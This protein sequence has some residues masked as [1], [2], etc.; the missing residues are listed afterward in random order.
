MKSEKLMDCIGQIDD[1]I[2]AEAD[3][4]LS[5]NN[6]TIKTRKDTKRMTLTFKWLVPVAA[7]LAITIASVFTVPN[8]IK[9][10]DVTPPPNGIVIIGD[11]PDG[12]DLNAAAEDVK[13]PVYISPMLKNAKDSAKPGDLIKTIVSMPGYW[14]YLCD[15][16]VDGV[17]YWDYYMYVSGGTWKDDDTNRRE[18]SQQMWDK[19]NAMEEAAFESFRTRAISELTAKIGTFEVTDDEYY[20]RGFTFIAN[21]SP[22]QID[23]LETEKVF[24]KL[25]SPDWDVPVFEP[26][27]VIS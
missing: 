19:L 12:F 7:C 10:P 1:S 14:D 25:W 23:L 13:N 16:E 22:E 24:M 20:K 6:P 27:S 17:T 8:L 3:I 5:E 15:F 21:L 11:K 2:I 9:S 26:E 18:D 4:I